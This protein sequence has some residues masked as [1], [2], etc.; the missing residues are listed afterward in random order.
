M[1][2]RCTTVSAA[3]VI[4]D[5]I[6]RDFVEQPSPHLIVFPAVPKAGKLETI[7]QKLTEIGVDEIRPWFASRSVAHW[8]ERKSASRTTRMQTVAKEAAMQSRRAWLP[9]VVAPA[10]LQDLPDLCFVLHEDADSRIGVVLPTVAP[11]TIG[12]IIGPEGG[13]DPSELE[14]LSAIGATIVSLGQQ[15]LRTET[16]ALVGPVLVLGHF[17]RL[18]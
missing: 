14:H 7:V 5:V 12:V 10:P 13:L 1:R 8:D 9:I 6:A 4:A 3:E 17:R 11:Q 15:V 18:G 2:A 16:A